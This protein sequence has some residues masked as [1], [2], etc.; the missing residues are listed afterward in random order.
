MNQ[1][2]R[3]KEFIRKK[4]VSQTELAQK[5]AINKSNI[6]RQLLQKKVKPEVIQAIADIL[7]ISTE[8]ILEETNSYKAN[9]DYNQLMRISDLQDRLLKAEEELK[10]YRRQFGYLLNKDGN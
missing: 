5:L 2:D 4:G 7:N 1:G 6:N 10:D 8:T 9:E 3:I